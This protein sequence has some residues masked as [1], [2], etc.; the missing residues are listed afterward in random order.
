MSTVSQAIPGGPTQSVPA[1]RLIATLAV[2]GSLAGAVIVS[3]FGW[4]EPRILANQAAATELAITQVL[5]E[6]QQFQTLFLYDDQLVHTLPAGVDSV[7]LEKVYEGFGAEGQRVGYAIVGAEPGFAD[8]IRLIFGYDSGSGQVLGMLVMENK[9][10]PGLGDKIVKD[11]AFVN[12]FRGRATPLQGVKP[13][14]GEGAANEIDMI[15]GATISSRAVIGIINRRIER[16]QPL[17]AAYEE[18]GG[19]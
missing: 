15:T 4:A 10:T 19:A 18:R 3:V 13:G 1:W 11:E 9:E 17:I 16:L 5:S 7:P 14:A 6:G 2:A 8:V 12:A